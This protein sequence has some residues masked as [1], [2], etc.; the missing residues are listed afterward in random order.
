MAVLS[1]YARIG[2]VIRN[3][4][5]K[6]IEGR[7]QMYIDQRTAYVPFKHKWKP[8]EVEQVMIENEMLRETLYAEQNTHYNRNMHTLLSIFGHST[9]SVIKQADSIEKNTQGAIKAQDAFRYVYE[10]IN[11][12]YRIPFN[13]RRKGE[14]KLQFA[15]RVGALP[16]VATYMSAL[17]ILVRTT[18]RKNSKLSRDFFTE[19]VKK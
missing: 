10:I 4:K 5:H 2:K 12:N 7:P 15:W 8:E 18:Y 1:K 13:S 9:S 19:I 11:I 17:D 3:H 16:L 6:P 14:S